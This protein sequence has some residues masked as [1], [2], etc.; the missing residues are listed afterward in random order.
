MRRLFSLVAFTYVEHKKMKTFQIGLNGFMNP[1]NEDEFDQTKNIWVGAKSSLMIEI[2]MKDNLDNVNHWEKIDVKPE[3]D[4]GVDYFLP[5]DL[6][7]LKE[8]L[9]NRKCS[10][11]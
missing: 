6:E 3:K 11:K 2:V 9:A 5:D 1:E 4:S 8:H 7:K 10:Y